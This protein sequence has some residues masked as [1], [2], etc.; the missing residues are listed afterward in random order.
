MQYKG[1]KFRIYPTIDQQKFLNETLG[2]CR[3]V[4]NISLDEAI[5][6]YEN[7]KLNIT[8]SKPKVSGFDIVK[9]LPIIKNKEE[10]KWLYN[11]S[12][13]ALQQKLLDLGKSFSNFFR[14]IK[15]KRKNRLS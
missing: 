5:K 4:Y 13:C 6:E 10:Y 11:Y 2:A 7:Y 1:I 9:K 3:K 12:S 14:D 8:L 15:I